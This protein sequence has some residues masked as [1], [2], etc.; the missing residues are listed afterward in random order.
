MDDD[1]KF[2]NGKTQRTILVFD[3]F[4]VFLSLLSHRHRIRLRVQNAINN[5]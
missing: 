2:D 4:R 3:R 5:D 1:G